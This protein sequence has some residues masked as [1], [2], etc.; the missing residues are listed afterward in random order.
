MEDRKRPAAH[1]NDDMA[2]PTKRQAVNGTSKAHPDADMP[3]KDDLEVRFLLSYLF[4]TEKIS[5]SPVL[6]YF[7]MDINPT[8][9]SVF[10]APLFI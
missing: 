9:A 1:S 4:P 7:A 8:Y 5:I 3:W 6:S 10:C 2:P